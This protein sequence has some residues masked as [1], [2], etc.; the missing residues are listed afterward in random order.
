MNPKA[1]DNSAASAKKFAQFVFRMSLSCFVASFTFAVCPLYAQ[2]QLMALTGATVID[3]SGNLP[4]LK[5]TIV[6]RGERIAAFGRDVK[7]P[8]SASVINLRG[9]TIIPG[10]ID[11]HGHMY[12]RATG[13]MRSQFDA[14]PLLYLA[15]GVTTVFSPGDFEPEGMIAFRERIRRGEMIG[16]RVLTAGPYF[17]N[18]PS[19][20]SWMKG[21]H[22]P[23]EAEEL[24]D[25]WKGRIDGVK[26]YT[27]I[28]E[29]EFLAV[30]KAA[31]KV[32][33]PV[34]GHLRSIN[35]KRAIELGINGLE[36]GIFAMPELVAN[37]TS[38]W[39]DDWCE[40][41][42]LD[43]NSCTVDELVTLIV[44]HRV[45]VDPTV[46]VFQV[47]QPDF[48]PVTPRWLE[49]LSPEARAHQQSLGTSI[50]KIDPGRLQC[51]RSAIQNQLRFVKKVHDQGGII[52]AGTDPVSP[53]LT[54]GYALHRELRNLVEAGMTPIE[55]IK[56][57]TLNA[58]TALRREKEFGS[59]STG[60]FADLVVVSGDPSINIE[61]VGN[62][63][64]VFKGGVQY[65]SARLRKLAELK[66]K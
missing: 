61:D 7:I 3:G 63:E 10:L 2:G 9:K 27:S 48:E 39:D 4:C 21:V 65:K 6:I 11:M 44:N 30:L 45:A 51:L 18:S 23:E 60:K 42:S 37:P 52:V 66:I 54:P 57:A 43:M 20:V 24:F 15:G 29:P 56:V 14:Y 58:A 5:C 41:A 16:P 59:I 38:N 53:R 49:F 26:F 55:A 62:V 35:A 13:T 32:G 50:R 46:I 34:T 17:D 33:L 8:K 1:F 47:L 36:H 25:K 12:A 22:S 28:T 40:L 64:I 31:H 19:A